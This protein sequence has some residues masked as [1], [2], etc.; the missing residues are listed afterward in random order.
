MTN[1]KLISK[2][3]TPRLILR[4]IKLEDTDAYFAA[5]SASIKELAPYWS[6]AKSGK[7]IDDIK[8]TFN[9][10]LECHAKA[11]LEQ[12]FFSIFSKDDNRFLGLIWIIRLNWFVPFFEIAYLLNTRET[13][14][15]YMSEAVNALSRAC[16]TVYAAKRISIQIFVNND[17]SNAIPRKLGFKME[18]EMENHFINFVNKE[19][20]NG[21]LYACCDI[22]NLPPLEVGIEV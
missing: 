9:F 2:I 16:F 5:E 8:G 11:Q 14:N 6:W 21:F 15:G 1:T 4:P 17:K 20:T 12:M 19:V 10:F 22:N 13:G 7:S 18:G 3:T